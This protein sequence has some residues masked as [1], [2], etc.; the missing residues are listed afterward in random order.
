MRS[1]IIAKVYLSVIKIVTFKK[2]RRNMG[3]NTAIQWTWRT[4]PNGIILPGFTWNGWWGCV[5]KSKGCMNCYAETYAPVYGHAGLWGPASTTQRWIL[6][7]NNW[8][9]PFTWNRKAQKLGHRLSVFCGS[10]MDIF[11][12]NAQLDLP[13]QWAF[14]I[15]EATPWL[16]WLLLTK[17]PENIR[18]MVPLSWIVYNWPDN[19]WA[20]CSVEDQPAADERLPELIRVPAPRRF[21]S[22]E[23]ALEAVDFVRYLHRLDWIICGGES[24]DNHRPFDLDWARSARDQVLSMR[25][26]GEGCYYFFKQVGGLTHSAGGRLLDGRTWDEIPPEFPHGR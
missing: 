9:K 18:K 26:A 16:N 3:E 11:E 22:Y 8:Q 15:M 23:P 4:L 25:A 13:R 20:G 7:A 10:M 12:E 6:S 2:E 14:A 5:R 19:V 1:R 17:R 21:V 24:G